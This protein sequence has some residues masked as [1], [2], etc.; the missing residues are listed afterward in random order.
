MTAA[1]APGAPAELW[2]DQLTPRRAQVLELAAEGLSEKEIAEELGITRNTVKKHVTDIHAGD[3]PRRRGALVVGARRTRRAPLALGDLMAKLTA[4]E[5]RFLNYQ[6]LPAS[7][8][9]RIEHL[10]VTRVLAIW[11]SLKDRGVVRVAAEHAG[12]AHEQLS[13]DQIDRL[14]RGNRAPIAPA[15]AE[16]GWTTET[17]GSW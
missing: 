5:R 14:M 10:T 15:N 8:I 12:P 7:E 1:T 9:A 6:G 17:E 11:R 3:Q 2:R 13:L 16:L 4:L